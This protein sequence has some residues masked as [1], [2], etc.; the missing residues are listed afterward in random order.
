MKVDVGAWVCKKPTPISG[1]TNAMNLS[2]STRFGGVFL[3]LEAEGGL[4]LN[5]V[6]ENMKEKRRINKISFS[7]KPSIPSR[8]PI[9][10]LFPTAPRRKAESVGKG[11]TD[12]FFSLENLFDQMENETS[13]R[14]RGVGKERGRGV[15]GRG[16]SCAKGWRMGSW[17]GYDEE[18]LK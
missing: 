18:D 7:A 4:L 14:E 12:V 6:K 5:T 3:S 16:E 13:Q 15:F 17:V 2:N 8:L 1:A 10:S 11:P 9:L